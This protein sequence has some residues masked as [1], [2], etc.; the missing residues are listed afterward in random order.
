LHAVHVGQ[1][2]ILTRAVEFF[3]IGVREEVL[4]RHKTMFAN[5]H[6]ENPSGHKKI[7]SPTEA[8]EG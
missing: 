2:T 7:P 4:D 3:A 8:D 5:S 1:R 6:R